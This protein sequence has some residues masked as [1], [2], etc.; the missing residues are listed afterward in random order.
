MRTVWS[1]ALGVLVALALATSAHA[2]PM[3][4]DDLPNMQDVNEI[5]VSSEGVVAYTLIKPRNILKGEPNGPADF[6]LY[7]A[8][9]PGNSR[10][11]MG[12]SVT[13]FD[14]QFSSDGRTLYFLAFKGDEELVSLY[15]MPLYG[16][17]AEELYTYPTGIS[18][19]AISDD[20]E[21]LYFI[22]AEF[23]RPYTETLSRL[24][25]RAYAHDEWQ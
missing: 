20:G 22:A 17:E 19:Y 12:G 4:I 24:G 23:A 7:V 1:F 18:D 9:Q 2:R 13:V 10:L 11:Y 14:V 8:R 6:H 15:R 25:F 3:Q 5:A 21:T 16:G